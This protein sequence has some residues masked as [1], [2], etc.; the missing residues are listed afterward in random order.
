M[1]SPGRHFDEPVRAVKVAA[2]FKDGIVGEAP[3][4]SVVDDDEAVRVSLDGLIRSLG[5][6]VATFHSGAAF[7]AAYS[8]SACVI[9]DLE[10]PGMSGIELKQA[11][12]A[13]GSSTPVIIITGVADTAA[14]TRAV[15]AGVVCV[16]RKPFTGDKLVESLEL[17]LAV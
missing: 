10:M 5:Y 14:H 3:L 17:A 8:R 16:L 4:I 13:A 2:A 15:D 1:I 12:V 7:L 11:L 9:S 6:R